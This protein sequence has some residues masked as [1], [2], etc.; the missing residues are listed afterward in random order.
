MLEPA[1][2]LRR[3]YNLLAILGDAYLKPKNGARAL[4]SVVG[5][6]GLDDVG[7][8]VLLL[9]EYL[10]HVGGNP[11]RYGAHVARTRPP[12]SFALA[13]P[14]CIFFLLFHT[15]LLILH[16]FN[17]NKQGRLPLGGL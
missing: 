2:T 4:L 12:G 11:Q 3:L 14:S 5:P 10:G 8:A 9:A 13:A 7:G 6:Y 15:F 17:P 1:V 16:R